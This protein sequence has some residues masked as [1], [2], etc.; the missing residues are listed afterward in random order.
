MSK[1]KKVILVDASAARLFQFRGDFIKHLMGMGHEVYC[2]APHDAVFDQK[3]AEICTEYQGLILHRSKISLWQNFMSFLDLFKF[4]K[5]VAPDTVLLYTPKP[6]IMGSV[7]A[8]LLGVKGIYSMIAGLGFI[9]TFTGE[10]LKKLVLIRVLLFAYKMAFKLNKLVFFINPDDRE[11]FLSRGSLKMEKTLMLNGEGVDLDYYYFKDT[12]PEKL[13]FLYVGR[14]LGD[15]GVREFIQASS[16]LKDQYPDVEFALAGDLDEA[17]PTTLSQE[18]VDRAKAEGKVHFLGEVPDIREELWNTSV[19]V[20]PSY[21]EG[22]PRS[23][24]EAMALGRAVIS[25]N[26]PGCRETVTEGEN[27]YLVEIR[28]SQDLKL[29]MELFI[30]DPTLPKKFGHKSYEYAKE[31]YDIHKINSQIS[32]VILAD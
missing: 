29:K 23:T 5:R 8:K 18:E 11:E 4:F 28:N 6:T 21:R 1:K 31:R 7:A 2:A 16:E 10:S 30:K 14:L 20:L 26:C 24:M 13:R 22:L 17:H 32:N 9:F 25:G 15:K 27:G 19:F 3:I 12:Y